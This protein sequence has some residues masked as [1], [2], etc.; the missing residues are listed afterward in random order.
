MREVFLGLVVARHGLYVGR[1]TGCVIAGNFSAEYVPL[2]GLGLRG[3]N[4]WQRARQ[5]VR[6]DYTGLQP[7]EQV[8]DRSVARGVHVAVYL[9]EM[10]FTCTRRG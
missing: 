1:G 6:V 4:T 9:Q 8:S 2:L 10:T 7:G 5:T 3:G